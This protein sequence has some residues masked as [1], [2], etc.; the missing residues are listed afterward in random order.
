MIRHKATAQRRRRW[1]K[2]RSGTNTSYFYL[3]WLSGRA[4]TLVVILVLIERLWEMWRY[5]PK[6]MHL[7][8]DVLISQLEAG[9]R[10]K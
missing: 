3:L 8:L 1:W 6:K 9:L 10:A 5:D 7:F 2:A 4:T